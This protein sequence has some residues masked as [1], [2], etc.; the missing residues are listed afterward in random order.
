MF[1]FLHIVIFELFGFEVGLLCLVFE[2]IKSIRTK[3]YLNFQELNLQKFNF[4]KVQI[5]I[6]KFEYNVNLHEFLMYKEYEC[7]QNLLKQLTCMLYANLL[8]HTR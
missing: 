5:V 2:G 1:N 8:C 3:S 7:V 6:G 4:F